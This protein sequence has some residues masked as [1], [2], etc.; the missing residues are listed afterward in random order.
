M[1]PSSALILL[2]CLAAQPRSGL[3]VATPGF[4]AR[5]DAGTLVQLADVDGAST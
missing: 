3:D 4:A 1:L 2:S 5:F